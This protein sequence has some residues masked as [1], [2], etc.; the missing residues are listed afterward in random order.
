MDRNHYERITQILRQTD[1][2]DPRMV[3]HAFRELRALGTHARNNGYADS[4]PATVPHTTI[5]A[6]QIHPPLDGDYI[7]PMLAPSRLLV[8][9]DTP[10]VDAGDTSN[11]VD[12]EFSAGGGWLIGWRGIAVDFTPGAG[13]AGRFESAAMAVRMFL[14]D[15]EELITNGRAADFAPFLTIFGESVS[16]TPILRRVDVKDTLHCLFRNLQPAGGSTLRPFVTFAYWREKYPG[17]C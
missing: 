4:Y 2:H 3:A 17:V 7:E 15:G 8:L 12:L 6:D 13:A 5:Q 9:P 16:M 1:Q 14:N 11:Q 10:D